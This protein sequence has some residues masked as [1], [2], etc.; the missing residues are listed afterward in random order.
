MSLRQQS[1]WRSDMTAFTFL[2]AKY[3]VGQVIVLSSATIVLKEFTLWR[4]V[5]AICE[6]Y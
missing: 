1:S 2:A 3:I 6:S 4:T 5:N